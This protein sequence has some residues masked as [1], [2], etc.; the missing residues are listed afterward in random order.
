MGCFST[1]VTSLSPRLLQGLALQSRSIRKTLLGDGKVGLFPH[2]QVRKG[3]SDAAST[4]KAEQ[5]TGEGNVALLGAHS[6]P[7]I[8]SG[9]DRPSV[10]VGFSLVFRRCDGDAA[11]AP[12][13]AKA[14]AA[15]AKADSSHGHGTRGAVRPR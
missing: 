8:P 11:D 10:L 13:G 12:D 6:T 15:P 9:M 1:P 7:G 2:G 14:G 4:L 5:T 3:G